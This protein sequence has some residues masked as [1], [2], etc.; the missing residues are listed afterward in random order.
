MSYQ[1]SLRPQSDKE[2]AAPA[3][4][5]TTPASTT[6]GG[7]ARETDI[8]ISAIEENNQLMV[9]ST[10]IE[11]DRIESAIKKLDIVPL[12]VQ[13]EARILEVTLSGNLNY[14]VQ[15]Y[16]AGLIG[17][18]TGSADANGNYRSHSPPVP[19][20]EIFTGNSHERHRASAGHAKIS[21]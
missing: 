17:T 5:G 16:L 15:W 3:T 20:E 8:R 9:Q 19:S 2:K 10:P 6:P 18:A 13:I 1:N 7:G 14:G 12:Q 11:W 4:T 21:K